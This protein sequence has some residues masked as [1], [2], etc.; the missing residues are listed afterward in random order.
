MAHQVP[1]VNSTR[2]L[3]SLF[4]WASAILLASALALA[5][6]WHFWWR[7]PPGTGPVALPV[8]AESF[9][10]PW[11]ER[12]VLLVGLGDSVTAGFGAAKGRSYFDR[13][14]GPSAADEYPEL[15]GLNLRAVLPNLSITNLSVSGSTSLQHVRQQLPRLTRQHPDTLGIIVLTTGGNDL[16]HNYGRTEPSEGALFGA[17]V[18]QAAPWVTNFAVR[19]GQMVATITNQF[20]GGAHVFLA[21]IY[22]PTDGLGDIG[23]AGP[24]PDWPDG[25]ALHTEFNR[26]IRDFA[27]RHGNVHLVPMHRAFLGHGI[28]CTQFWR[29]HYAAADP[30][31]WFHDN[32]EDPNDRGYDA[33]RRLFLREIAA[34]LGPRPEAR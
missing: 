33:I 19:L 5:A 16:I 17:T 30:H 9:S 12:R 15:R 25:L 1:R 21:D 24:L 4:L 11:T 13:L 23:R 26:I 10:Q 6:Y 22:D 14:A 34:V 18:A 2:R 29:E 31:Y 20:P 32:L 8:P 27:G 3:R 7:R 28:H